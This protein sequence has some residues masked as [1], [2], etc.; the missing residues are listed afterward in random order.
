MLSQAILQLHESG[1]LKW[2]IVKKCPKEAA[3]AFK[4]TSALGLAN[5]GGVFVVLLTG[6]CVACVTAVVALLWRS[7]K[8][9]PEEREPVC[10]ELCRELRFTL[11]CGGK[12]PMRTKGDDRVPPGAGSGENGLPFMPLAGYGAVVSKDSFS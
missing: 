7:R 8:A 6:S 4:G 11:T 12:K 10:M 9:L 5:V 1:T 2:H 3:S